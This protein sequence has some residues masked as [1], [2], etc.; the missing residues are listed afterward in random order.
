M[1]LE[2]FVPARSERG[3]ALVAVLGVFAM[4]LIL[5]TLIVSSVVHGLGFSTSSRASVQSQAAADAGISAVR[6]ALYT[7]SNCN[8]Q[9]TP[10]VYVSASSPTYTVAVERN[11]GAGWVTGCP[12]LLTSQVRLTSTGTAAAKG[13]SGNSAG[14]V[15]KVQATYE[16]LIP[17]VTPSGV[18][19]YLHDG[20]VIEANSSLDLSEG[21][22]TGLMVKNGTLNCDKNNGVI[23]GSLMVRGNLAFGGSCE[24]TGSAVVTGSTTL[25]SGRID[26]N[27]TSGSVSPN[28]PGSRVGGTYTQSAAAPAIPDWT[29][30]TY[31]PSDWKTSLGLPFEVRAMNASCSLS[32]GNLGGTVSGY[33]VIINALGCSSGLSANNNTTVSL[34]SDVVIFANKFDFD[35]VNSLVFKSASSASYRLWFITPDNGPAGDKSPTCGSGQ[36]PF[37]VKNGFE[38]NKPI[39]ALLY[40]PCA[41]E[42][43]NGFTWNGQIYAGKYSEIKNN[44]S[45]TFVPVGAG[46]VDFDNA[47]VTTQVTK[48]QPG[49]LESMRNIDG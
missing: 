3:S 27:L 9:P 38:V 20:A 30:L 47:T 23:N 6:A 7:A 19:M 8:A 26:G 43:K 16:Y 45:F 41:F 11:N 25:G 2:R 5:T 10:G 44:P 35:G 49:G 39:S 17:G 31:Q 33:P 12:T 1:F 32:S 46:G 14:D 21:G 36:G 4:G 37:T 13:V 42:G 18:A 40:T 15:S 34:T 28:P 29:N 22:N 48:P 24:V